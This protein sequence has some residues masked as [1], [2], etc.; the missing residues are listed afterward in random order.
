MTKTPQLELKR[1]DDQDGGKIATRRRGSAGPRTEL[2]KQRSKLNAVKYGI[3]SSVMLLGSES[4]DEFDRLVSGL[5][6]HY[7]PVGTLEETLVDQLVASL[8]RL[9]RLLM[10]EKAEITGAQPAEKISDKD[11]L[12]NSVLRRLMPSSG[13]F[14]TAFLTLPI[15]RDKW[16]RIL[17]LIQTPLPKT[18]SNLLRSRSQ[19]NDRLN[20]Q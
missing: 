19:E 10:A 20:A 4:K 15:S 7:R 3:F 17:D 18:S 2:G 6:D 13:T 1:R 9:R 8:W 5:M 11:M 16:C 12:R 14:E